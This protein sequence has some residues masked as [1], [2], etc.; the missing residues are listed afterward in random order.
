M[1]LSLNSNTT[2]G[3][4]TAFTYGSSEFT[5]VLCVVRVAQYLVFQCHYTVDYLWFLTILLSV[6]VRFTASDCPFDIFKLILQ[7]TQLTII[8]K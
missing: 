6:V 2:S 7:R 5:P 8:G 4:G 3:A 1:F